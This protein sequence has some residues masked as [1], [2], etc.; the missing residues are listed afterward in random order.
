MVGSHRE[1]YHENVESFNNWS[2]GRV[3]RSRGACGKLRGV[4]FDP[5]VS[6]PLSGSR[7]LLELTTRDPLFAHDR[8]S[9]SLG[10]GG[11]DESDGAVRAA[12]AT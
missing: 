7:N 1:S 8:S 6:C 9:R 12:P 2:L 5:A 4:A 11:G 3:G 10:L